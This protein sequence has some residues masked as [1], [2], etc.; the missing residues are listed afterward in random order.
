[1]K[2]LMQ[3]LTVILLATLTF[4]VQAQDKKVQKTTFEC[5]LDCPSCETKIM[6]AIPYEKG[7]KDVKVDFDK[8]EVTVEYKTSKNSDARLKKALE[9]MGYKVAIKREDSATTDKNKE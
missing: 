1:M 6:K 5:S 8:K 7:V 2:K 3:L 9:K 4:N